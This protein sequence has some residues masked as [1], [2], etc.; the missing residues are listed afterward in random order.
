VKH[1]N[2]TNRYP[3]RVCKYFKEQGYGGER[4]KRLEAQE[5]HVIRKPDY[6]M[7]QGAYHRG[8][9]FRVTPATNNRTDGNKSYY[10]P[11]TYEMLMKNG[12]E[13]PELVAQEYIDSVRDADNGGEAF[14]SNYEEIKL[15]GLR[16]AA[17][18]ARQELYTLL[19]INGQI[20][21][22]TSTSLF[23]AFRIKRGIESDQNQIAKFSKSNLMFEP[24][25]LTTYYNQFQDQV[26][27]IDGALRM[28]QENER[29]FAK[30]LAMRQKMCVQYF[31]EWMV[32]FINT[33][34][35]YQKAGKSGL[36]ERH[37]KRIRVLE[38]KHF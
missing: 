35:V 7:L 26:T 25:A 24:E 5:D 31:T 13:I 34:E 9:T 8:V 14:A 21:K 27:F 11:Q 12:Y 2:E 1:Y 38:K 30:L 23:H 29:Q 22:G 16:L 10:N 20:T 18:Y 6:D 37:V 33:R 32:Y 28:H 36:Y 4:Q 19:M 3:K 15:E 17:K